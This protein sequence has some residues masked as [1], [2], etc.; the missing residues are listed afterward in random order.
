MYAEL[1]TTGKLNDYLADLNEQAEAMFSRLVKQLSEKE[2]VTEALK[3]ENQMLWVQ[4][5]NN[6]RNRAMEIVYTNLIYA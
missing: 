4:K 3:E 5:I 6:I 1:L 2:G